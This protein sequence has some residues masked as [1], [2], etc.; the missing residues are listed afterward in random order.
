MKVRISHCSTS[1][2]NYY[3]CLTDKVS[4]FINR[5]P[6]TGDLIYLVVKVNKKSLCG[7]RFILDEATD[8]KPWA[9]AES[10]VNALTIKNIE[11]CSPFDISLLSK[12]GG[13]Y[14]AIK[15]IQ[16]AKPI[17]EQV[18]IQILDDTFTKNKSDTL[19]RFDIQSLV[20]EIEDNEETIIEDEE[21]LKRLAKE[22]PNVK[23]N[24]MGTFQTVQFSNETDKIKGLERLVNENFYFLFPQFPENKTLLIPENRL[25]KTKGFKVDG[26]NV[27]GIRTIPDGILIEFDKKLKNPF[28]INL[29]EYECYGER[30]QKEIDKSSYLNSIIIPQLMR[31]AS[32]F[33]IITDEQTRVK[34]VESWVDK[35]IAYINSDEAQSTKFINWIK[36]IYPEIKERS[37]EREIEKLLI[38]SFKTNL[39]VLLIIDELS[40]EQ[41]S[42][43][44][45]VVSSFKLAN[46]DTNVQFAG[47]VV[48]LVQK[49]NMINNESEYALTIQ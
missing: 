1:L 18:A 48:R 37:I 19:F 46:G 25:F 39:R 44:K 15:Y 17:D 30:K 12:V 29:I 33:S 35:I 8:Y 13:K 32:A 23:V 9:D 43:I 2:E 7:A 26:N 49:I 40:S 10:Y 24:I 4:G 38:D 42:T 27:S 3:I 31:F 21:E 34:T 5:G 22:V 41:K 45:N 28:R 36:E 47:Y 6:Q 16:G 20:T 11:Y 14:W